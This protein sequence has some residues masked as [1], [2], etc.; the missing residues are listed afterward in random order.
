M[1]DLWQFFCRAHGDFDVW[2]TDWSDVPVELR[3]SY[4]K[5]P[6]VFEPEDVRKTRCPVCRIPCYP[7][8][9][10]ESLAS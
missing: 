8:G 4:L 9:P 3:P 5:P 6:T 1:N 7:R 2:G 10:L